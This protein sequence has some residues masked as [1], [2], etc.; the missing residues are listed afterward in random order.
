[1]FRGRQDE[2]EL[3]AAAT[4]PAAA[5]VLADAAGVADEAAPQQ[6]DAGKDDGERHRRQR[7]LHPDGL[8]GNFK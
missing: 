8:D 1:M 6:E 7:D 4:A 5:A 2:F 3:S